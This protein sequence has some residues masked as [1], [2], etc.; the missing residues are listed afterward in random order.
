MKI[1]K[2]RIQQ[3]V[4]EEYT[5]AVKRSSRSKSNAVSRAELRRLIESMYDSSLEGVAHFS[6]EDAV[7]D[8]DPDDDHLIHD[9][10]TGDLHHYDAMTGKLTQVG[11]HPGTLST[12]A[13]NEHA[14]T[15]MLP[16]KHYS[17]GQLLDHGF[18]LDHEGM[19]TD[20]ESAGEDLDRDY[21]HDHMDPE[22]HEDLD[23]KRPVD[24][25]MGR[26]VHGDTAP[27]E[28]HFDSRS[29]N[30]RQADEDAD[31]DALRA[32][33]E[34]KK[35]EQEYEQNL[36]DRLT[37][38]QRTEFFEANQRAV[39][40]FTGGILGALGLTMA[41]IAQGPTADIDPK[42]ADD[43]YS[44]IQD[45]SSAIHSM[46][47]S[48]AI[49]RKT[50]NIDQPSDELIGELQRAGVTVN[51]QGGHDYVYMTN[52]DVLYAVMNGL[53]PEAFDQITATFN[54]KGSESASDELGIPRRYQTSTYTDPHELMKSNPSLNNIE[55]K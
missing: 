30:Q 16:L 8:A 14:G 44:Y 1:S 41:A 2:R 26:E 37:P 31:A 33:E 35:L 23:Y 15:Y 36:K 39:D 17:D 38:S 5:R 32:E 46:I 52:H 12:D 29:A 13:A 18:G 25:L 24:M 47:N 22:F 40:A 34:T 4:K 42:F 48:G 19:M 21:T 27:L 20:P 28:T 11:H 6:I 55:Y 54:L 43:P 50:V 9:K 51:Y 7:R 10:S 49:P 53:N 45:N 3:I